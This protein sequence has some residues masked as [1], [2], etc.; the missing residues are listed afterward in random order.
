MR[1]TILCAFLLA[2]CASG[3][4]FTKE[5]NEK[6]VEVSKGQRFKI[7]L[8]ASNNSL[9]PRYRFSRHAPEVR[10]NAVDYLGH[11]RDEPD[12]EMDGAAGKDHYRFKALTRGE[13][14]IQFTRVYDRTEHEHR[15][16]KGYRVTV[17][18]R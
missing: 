9:H 12:P 5:H 16:E 6:T 3:P 1:V 7:T 13:V 8:R 15:H 17:V 14:T 11:S 10:G 2:G 18:V 4:V